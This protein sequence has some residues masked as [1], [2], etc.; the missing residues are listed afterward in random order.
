MFISYTAKQH[1]RA[2]P[3]SC[4]AATSAPH[5]ESGDGADDDVKEE[6]EEEGRRAW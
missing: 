2:E 3:I 5:Q 1:V 6:E 4:S